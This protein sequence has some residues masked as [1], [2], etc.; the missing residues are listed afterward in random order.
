L[1]EKQ[2]KNP[3]VVSTRINEF[4][5]TLRINT[6]EYDEKRLREKGEIAGKITIENQENVSVSNISIASEISKTYEKNMTLEFIDEKILDTTIDFKPNEKKTITFV[7]RFPQ[8]LNDGKYLFTTKAYSRTGLPVGIL[9]KFAE[10]IKGQNTFLEID[11]QNSK[12]IH[13]GQEKHPL[14]GPTFAPKSAPTIILTVKNPH[15]FPIYAI[16]QFTIYPWVHVIGSEPVESYKDIPIEFAAGSEKKLTFTLPAYEKAL[17]YLAYLIFV[18]RNGMS[19]SGIQ[20]FRWVIEGKGGRLLS[21]KASDGQ[22]TFGKTKVMITTSTVGSADG[23]TVNDVILR[24][25][26]FSAE[27]SRDLLGIVEQKVNISAQPEKI[28]FPF[29]FSSRLIPSNE[30]IVRGE[31]LSKDQDQVFDVVEEKIPLEIDKTSYT[32]LL[33]RGGVV[34]LIVVVVI[35]IFFF[36]SKRK[37]FSMPKRFNLYFFSLTFLLLS[38][39]VILMAKTVYALNTTDCNR[40]SNSATCNSFAEPFGEFFASA[41]SEVNKGDTVVITGTAWINYDCGNVNDPGVLKDYEIDVSATGGIDWLKDPQ[42]NVVYFYQ[43]VNF[44]TLEGKAKGPYGS[45]TISVYQK[46]NL[47]AQCFTCV[48]YETIDLPIY[49]KEQF[50]TCNPQSDY[51]CE[52]TT[53]YYKD[54]S[55]CSSAEGKACDYDGSFC[56]INCNNMRPKPGEPAVPT[57]DPSE[58]QHTEC[59]NTYCVKIAGSGNDQCDGAKYTNDPLCQ[60]TKSPAPRPTY[61][62]PG[63]IDPG[64]S[65]VP[66]QE[67]L[68]C[69]VLAAGESPVCTYSSSGPSNCS[70]RDEKV[71]AFWNPWAQ[72]YPSNITCGL[73]YE[74]SDCFCFGDCAFLADPA[75][76]PYPGSV[77]PYCPSDAT[78]TS[79]GYCGDPPLKRT[80]CL[81]TAPILPIFEMIT[82][83]Q[84]YSGYKIKKAS[85]IIQT[86]DVYIE[87]KFDE[88]ESGC[89]EPW[90][91]APWGFAATET[92]SSPSDTTCGNSQQ[93]NK[94]NIYIDGVLV[95]SRNSVGGTGRK[96]YFLDTSIMTDPDVFNHDVIKLN[97]SHTLEICANNGYTKGTCVTQPFT[98]SAIPNGEVIINLKEHTNNPSKYT[99]GIVNPNPPNDFFSSTSS[100]GLELS[101]SVVDASITTVCSQYG[102][103]VC[104]PNNPTN[105]TAA[106]AQCVI[107]FDNVNRDIPI[108]PVNAFIQTFTMRQSA[109]E[110]YAQKAYN[111]KLYYCLK[112]A[113]VPNNLVGNNSYLCTSQSNVTQPVLK[114]I[115]DQNDPNFSSQV[116][117]SVNTPAVYTGV[118]IKRNP[119]YYYGQ[120]STQD[121]FD[122]VFDKLGGTSTDAFAYY[123]L[124]DVSY[125][126]PDELVSRFPFGIAPYDADDTGEPWLVINT[127]GGSAMDRI[128]TVV[129]NG[130]G[131][132]KLGQALGVSPKNWLSTTYVKSSTPFSSWSGFREYMLARKNYEELKLTGNGRFPNLTPKTIYYYPGT[133]VLTIDNTDAQKF[134]GNNGGNII[135]VS[136]AQVDIIP[137]QK[138]FPQDTSTAHSTIIVAPTIRF[139]NDL[140]VAQGVFIADTL[141]LTTT[142]DNPSTPEDREDVSTTPLKIKGN[143]VITNRLDTGFLTR[144]RNVDTDKPSLFVIFD[145]SHYANMLNL[146]ST[147]TYKWVELVQ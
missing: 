11:W 45:Y 44:F 147:S 96:T 97:G 20:Q 81:S 54:P 4:V 74:E 46:I 38:T 136:D 56:Q 77:Y 123:K 69:Q 63:D 106:Q 95:G 61:S 10:N 111:T 24:V 140:Q 1:P 79:A 57:L 17:P 108:S 23:S 102:V 137:N 49:I 105:C 145:P 99:D 93:V 146:F 42:G 127:N 71:G 100:M 2:Q 139:G 30:I 118:V 76:Y 28:S 98:K 101:P 33:A 58:P 104:D 89:N 112:P 87:W 8:L 67:F 36:R 128:G 15:S 121:K 84:G 47:Y 85:P 141:Y 92:P 6:Y 88:G 109:M 21:F 41:P 78:H 53:N 39:F 70:T 34:I 119:T 50:Y 16:P 22:G 144:Q 26:A 72:P 131:S 82:E 19:I 14:S 7:H 125:I 66:P 126:D 115:F 52:L 129:S 113:H 12:V 62:P 122:L 29:E 68:T 18:D 25:K 117:P 86:R 83:E 3:P 37:R 91:F 35:L 32:R 55:T 135:L 64:P 43:G 80:R 120:N 5:P 48:S 116:S 103:S 90:R 107:Q 27:K 60:P 133:G 94:F 142:Q 13:K 65:P 132:Y 40:I 143:L 110:T 31:L 130:G 134:N 73:V 59:L 138:K 75:I 114:A 9:S 51:T 124:K